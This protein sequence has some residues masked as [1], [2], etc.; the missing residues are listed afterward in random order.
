MQ[1]ENL[2]TG[3]DFAAI[4]EPLI[5]K[6][7]HTSVNTHGLH[8]REPRWPERGYSPVPSIT[9]SEKEGQL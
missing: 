9:C 4:R 8:E 7:S 1:G 6:E 5:G 2:V 3:G